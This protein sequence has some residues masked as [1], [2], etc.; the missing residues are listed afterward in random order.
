MATSHYSLNKSMLSS[1]VSLLEQRQQVGPQRTLKL[2]KPCRAAQL[3]TQW[4]SLSLQARN[5]AEHVASLLREAQLT[6]DHKIRLVTHRDVINGQKIADWLLE[7]RVVESRDEALQ[8]GQQLVV[9]N[10]LQG[11]NI[12]DFEDARNC[13][14]RFPAPLSGDLAP[15]LLAV[16]PHG[17]MFGWLTIR[18]SKSSLRAKRRYCVLAYHN[19]QH[20]LLFYADDCA[21]KP[22]G[23]VNFEK[24]NFQIRYTP[25]SHH[26]GFQVRATSVNG[27]KVRLACSAA[28]EYEAE[29]WV[30][31]FVDAGARYQ[32]NV[33]RASLTQASSVYD[34]TVF[35]AD[36]KPVSLDRFQGRVLLLVP[37]ALRDP[38]TPRSITQLQSIYTRLCHEG[39]G[40]EIVAFPTAQLGDALP[41][42][43]EETR[44]ILQD[45]NV[46]FA[47]MAAVRVNGP[48]AEPLFLYLRH[49]LPTLN[50]PFI[51]SSCERFLIDYRGQPVKRHS[52]SVAMSKL[53]T[54]LRILLDRDDVNAEAKDVLSP[55]KKHRTPVYKD[56]LNI[57]GSPP[58][59]QVSRHT[60]LQDLPLH[61]PNIVTPTKKRRELSDVERRT[62]R[63]PNPNLPY[64]GKAVTERSFAASRSQPQLGP[65]SQHSYDRGYVAASSNSQLRYT[66]PPL[67]RDLSRLSQHSL[68]HAYASGHTTPPPAAALSPL[69]PLRSPNRYSVPQT[70]PPRTMDTS[71]HS[72]LRPPHSVH[73]TTS[74][75]SHWPEPSINSSAAMLLAEGWRAEQA[76][77]LPDVSSRLQIAQLSQS[78]GQT[79]GWP[80]FIPPSSPAN[81]DRRRSSPGG[82][83]PVGVTPGLLTPKQRPPHP[84]QLTP[85]DVSVMMSFNADEFGS[86]SED[87]SDLD[88]DDTA[89]LPLDATSLMPV[90]LADFASHF[91]QAPGLSPL[92]E[93]APALNASL[94]SNGSR[95]SQGQG[96]GKA[97]TSLSP[98]FDSA[99]DS[100]R[101]DRPTSLAEALGMAPLDEESKD[102]DAVTAGSLGSMTSQ[103]ETHAPAHASTV[104]ASR[105]AD[106]DR[107]QLSALATKDPLYSPS[108]P[109]LACHAIRPSHAQQ[110]PTI[111][112]DSG[113]ADDAL[114]QDE[115]VPD[116]FTPRSPAGSTDT[117]PS[118][119]SWN[120][121]HHDYRRQATEGLLSPRETNPT[122]ILEDNR[123][124]RPLQQHQQQAALGS[125]PGTLA[126]NP[127]SVQPTMRNQ[128]SG[129]SLDTVV[130]HPQHTPM[131]GSGSSGPPSSSP[132]HSAG[133]SP[134][135]R[136]QHRHSTVHLLHS[137]DAVILRRPAPAAHS[138]NSALL[139]T[140]S[141]GLGSSVFGSALGSRQDTAL[142]LLREEDPVS[143]GSLFQSRG[144]LSSRSPPLYAQHP[145]SAYS[146]SSQDELPSPQDKQRRHLASAQAKF[147]TSPPAH[148]HPQEQLYRAQALAKQQ[149]QV[150]PVVLRRKPSQRTASAPPP[151]DRPMSLPPNKGLPGQP[152]QSA[153]WPRAQGTASAPADGQPK[154]YSYPMV[155]NPNASPSTQRIA[156]NAN[157]RRLLQNA[158]NTPSV[159]Q[160]FAYVADMGLDPTRE[161]LLRHKLFIKRQNDVIKTLRNSLT[162]SRDWT[163][164]AVPGLEPPRSQPR[165]QAAAAPVD[166]VL[167][168]R[169]ALLAAKLRGKRQ[170]SPQLNRTFAGRHTAGAGHTP[171]RMNRSAASVR[172]MLDTTQESATFV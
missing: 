125:H 109:Q 106:E 38:S 132:Y 69:K 55:S 70:Q 39:C 170:N 172:Q 15:S 127:I 119:V 74:A 9:G 75:E 128:V 99:Q 73:P 135:L 105:L 48:D 87:E 83:A 29:A 137:D 90:N 157:Q 35:D 81:S 76:R 37:L 49:Q 103:S 10:L 24:A 7:Q 98:R 146:I 116:A 96:N 6:T 107:R 118:D 47:V 46:T 159:D 71:A 65:F 13:W 8:V 148:R 21:N 26:K 20:L 147:A 171:S 102:T 160:S 110:A 131:P 4:S 17:Q 44:V 27:S 95:R 14:Y 129:P 30:H 93:S 67:E 104:A 144:D 43:S 156:L 154:R 57:T 112:I 143:S 64:E 151:V 59:L 169:R 80:T 101:S 114:R 145:D 40:F 141:S 77:S 12:S 100:P 139:T 124:N 155:A 61:S 56:L 68:Q 97:R 88:D 53:L 34:F 72:P 45:Y 136:Q 89:P 133:A 122:V 86:S 134:L 41:L 23:F 149:Q 52:P 5:E 115:G 117:L 3:A 142:S 60:A 167:A 94:T 162:Q 84:P 152:K 166:Q 25:H 31:A 42:S 36:T 126:A 92:T 165:T 168:F 138:P 123:N 22:L 111:T 32:E 79:G 140:R 150:S 153:S 16:I 113:S 51:H 164:V 54:D 121:L 78:P 19:V 163:G 11:V 130:L 58:K 108:M 82:A 161:E 158:L 28:N 85:Q 18:R 120:A 2:D 50:G 33:P 91:H 63:R 66:P 62:P 1:T